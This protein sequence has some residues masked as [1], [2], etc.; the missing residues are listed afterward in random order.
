MYC[1]TISSVILPELTAKYPRAYP[2]KPLHHLTDL[3]RR[4]ITDKHVDVI[5]CYL[6]RYDLQFMFQGNLSQQIAHT[7]RHRS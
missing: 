1:W 7:N 4:S 2:L 3:L 6:P 5:A